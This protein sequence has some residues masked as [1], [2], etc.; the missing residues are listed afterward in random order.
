MP[1]LQVS[2]PSTAT[3]KR[4][5]AKLARSRAFRTSLAQTHRDTQW[6]TPDYDLQITTGGSGSGYGNELLVDHIPSL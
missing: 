6:D 4:C 5:G 3:W 1:Q 2:P